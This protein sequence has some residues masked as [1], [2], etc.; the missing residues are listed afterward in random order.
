MKK[1]AKTMISALSTSMDDA[2]WNNVAPN[3]AQLLLQHRLRQEK[4]AVARSNGTS[5]KQA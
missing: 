2:F 1:Y 3:G 4:R 5:S